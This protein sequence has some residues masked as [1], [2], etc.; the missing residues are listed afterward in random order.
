[1]DILPQLVANGII[2]GALYALLA[3]G[4]NLI[5]GAA[6]F[7]DFSYGA[8]AIAGAY[9]AFFFSHT[10]GLP[11]LA[12]AA[13][14]IVFSAILA[15][16]LNVFIYHPLRKRRATTM[17]LLV[18]SLGAFTLIQAVIAMLFTSQFRALL[19]SEVGTREI[20]GVYPATGGATVT[21][22]HILIITLAFIVAALLSALLAKTTFGKSVRAVSDDAEVAMFVGINTEKI[23]AL[24]FLLGGA[25]AGLAGVLSALDTGMEPTRGFSLL[26]KGVIAAIIGG[27]GDVRGGLL[28]GFLLGLAENLGIWAISAG[29]K[30]AIAFAI[31]IFFLLFR[32]YGIMNKK[33]KV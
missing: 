29:W 1:M 10:L 9:A 8:V 6:K 17:V 19:E 33:Q 25:I 22:V 24:V 26:L 12:G 15:M 20:F 13:F 21:D 27:F 7:F 5:Y 23:I 11:L 2:A 31:L 16:L 14:G 18:A 32:P 30:D 3:L 4:F 28:G